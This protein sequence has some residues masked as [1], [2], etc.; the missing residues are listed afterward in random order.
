ME[1]LSDIFLSFMKSL[2]LRLNRQTVQF[3]FIEESA[4]FPLLSRAIEFLKYRDPMVRTGAQSTILNIFKIEEGKARKYSLKDDI[5][6]SFVSEVTGQLEAHHNSIYELALEYATYAAQ[7]NTKEFAGGKMGE[8]IENQISSSVD[9]LEDWLYYLDDLFGLNIPKL[10]NLICERITT[11]YVYPSLLKPLLS[12][13]QWAESVLFASNVPGGKGGR[14]VS[15]TGSPVKTSSSKKA[16]NDAEKSNPDLKSISEVLG[17][18]GD[19]VEGDSALFKDETA[20]ALVVA[21]YLLM[22][23]ISLLRQF[24]SLLTTMCA[25]LM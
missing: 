4:T 12:D 20:V 6:N 9:A 14:V 10:T 5:L 8:R 22:Q 16:M 11:Q 23:V 18:N 15:K 24:T 19:E 2:S 13:T 21:L 3:F 25:I 1:E 17:A 7:S